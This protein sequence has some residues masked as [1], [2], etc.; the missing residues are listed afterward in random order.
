MS[1]TQCPRC[2]QKALSVATR[3]PRCGDPFETHHYP[4]SS[5]R[6]RIPA[7]LILVGLGAIY[8]GFDILRRGPGVLEDGFSPP[9][10]AIAPVPVP[11]PP[12]TPPAPAPSNPLPAAPA[13]VV[14]AEPRAAEPVA[15][16]SQERRYTTIWANVREAR[17]PMAPVVT[18]LHP[19]EPV[20][21]DSLSEEWYRVVA[22]GQKLGYVYSALVDTAPPT[23]RN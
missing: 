20:L 22:E 2:G 13:P 19:G 15:G 18:V 4:S 8:F 6:R 10:T 9:P 1:Y 12:P 17:R 11:K 21:V 7:A 16:N 14:V 5:P 3:C 23:E